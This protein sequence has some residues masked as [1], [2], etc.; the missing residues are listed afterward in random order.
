MTFV[1]FHSRN[2]ASGI[3][4]PHYLTFI[5]IYSPGGQMDYSLTLQDRQVQSVKTVC[6]CQSKFATAAT[7]LK[8]K[9]Q[10]ECC[11]FGS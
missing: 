2:F 7:G 6:I 3:F 11:R 9:S 5:V 1:F 10:E 4:P 8:K